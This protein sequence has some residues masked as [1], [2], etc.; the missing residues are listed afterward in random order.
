MQ[1][2]IRKR[3]PKT[4]LH[5][6]RCAL[7]PDRHPIPGW[8]EAVKKPSCASEES[9][10]LFS[11][12]PMPRSLPRSLRPPS[13]IAPQFLLAHGGLAQTAGGPNNFSRQPTC[14]VGGQEHC[15]QSDVRGLPDAT[16]WR[17]GKQ[18]LL[19]IGYPLP[20]ATTTGLPRLRPF[21]PLLDKVLTGTR[22][23][24]SNAAATMA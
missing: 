11:I 13:R 16:E 7:V 21:A 5:L 19:E 23:L 14:L 9:L 10:F 3:Q 12:R 24:A 4:P 15:D 22:I 8:F 1:E 2:N 20:S 17:H 18:L 6:L